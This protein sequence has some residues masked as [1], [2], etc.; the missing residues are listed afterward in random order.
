VCVADHA[1]RSEPN[2]SCSARTVRVDNL[3]PLSTEPGA[4]LDARF[5]GGGDAL[6]T[7]SDRPAVV[8]GRL[9]DAHGAPVAGARVCVATRAGRAA[10]RVIATPLTNAQGEFSTR[11]PG[12]PSRAVRIAH[13]PS[14]ERAIEE[15]LTLRSRAM[16]RLRLRPDRTLSNGE[17][18]RFMVRIPG[19]AN[20]RRSVFVLARVGKRWVRIAGGKTRGSGT[21]RGRY[22]FR[23]T[24][25]TRRYAF[26]AVVPKQAGYPYEAGRSTVARA[27]V[28]D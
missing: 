18:L 26:R 28:S 12:G 9:R 24:T 17:E 7:R 10:E 16:P 15:H 25:G 11:I 1:Y 3:C 21:W 2:R 4:Q 20:G 27:T 5:R 14:S 23:S 6:A 8:A 19:P 22:R 13:W